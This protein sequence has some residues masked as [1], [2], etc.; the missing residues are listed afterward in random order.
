MP[1]ASPW[2]DHCTIVFTSQQEGTY[3]TGHLVCMSCDVQLTSDRELKIDDDDCN[4]ILTGMKMQ[5]SKSLN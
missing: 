2:S 1:A 4:F 3:L 5:G